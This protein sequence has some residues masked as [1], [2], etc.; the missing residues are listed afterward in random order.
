MQ[1]FPP[2]PHALVVV[3]RTHAPAEQQPA[4]DVVSQTHAPDA[5]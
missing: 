5:Q 2:L 1:A 4:H 3:P